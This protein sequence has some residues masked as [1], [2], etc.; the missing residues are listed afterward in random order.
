MVGY[1][2]FRNSVEGHIRRNEFLDDF[3]KP[4]FLFHLFPYNGRM[5]RESYPE[6]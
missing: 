2:G 4:T 5:L 6:G 3:L 1:R